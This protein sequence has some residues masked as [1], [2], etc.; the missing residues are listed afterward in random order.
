MRR[1]RRRASSRRRYARRSATWATRSSW[2]SRS[3]APGGQARRSC[4]GT[5]RSPS[6]PRQGRRIDAEDTRGRRESGRACQ[7]ATAA[8]RGG[9]ALKF[10][11]G[12]RAGQAVALTRER[13]TIGRAGVQLA[14]IERSGEAFRLK[15]VEGEPPLRSTAGRPT[16][17]AYRWRPGTSSKS[18]APARVRRWRVSSS[19]GSAPDGAAA[20]AQTRR[21]RLQTPRMNL[22]LVARIRRRPDSGRHSASACDAGRHMLLACRAC[23]R[24][25]DA[26][27]SGLQRRAPED[28]QVLDISHCGRFQ[29]RF[30]LFDAAT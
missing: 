19:P 16:P 21:I 11:S 24:L 20:S 10:L 18:W 12:P 8:D 15:P 6:E 22:C 30:H 27:S 17:M 28:T 4:G 9:P 7:P 1:F 13:T 3:C 2:R 23:G 14:A 29:N 25:R 26:L 5:G